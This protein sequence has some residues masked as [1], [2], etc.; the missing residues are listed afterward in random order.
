MGG[1]F[2]L[3]SMTGSPTCPVQVQDL[4]ILRAVGTVAYDALHTTV[5]GMEPLALHGFDRAVSSSK[6][7]G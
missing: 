7:H 1:D 4:R 3:T 5:H 2:Y 6:C